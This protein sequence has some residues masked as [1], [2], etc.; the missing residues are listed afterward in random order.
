MILHP[1][2]STFGVA[3]TPCGAAQRTD[4]TPAQLKM[5]GRPAC[6]IRYRTKRSAKG[7]CL[8]TAASYWQG[9]IFPLRESP[10]E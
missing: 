2:L 3:A 1:K 9:L 4:A 6:Q 7:I 8:E 10:G 5:I